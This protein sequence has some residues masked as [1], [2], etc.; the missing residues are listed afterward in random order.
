M[1]WTNPAT[2]EGRE[3]FTET[4]PAEIERALV[5]AERAF[6]GWRRRDF[7]E[8]ARLMRGAARLLRERKT[9]YGR[10][11]ALEMGKPLAQGEAEAEK[12]AWACE[13]YADR[14]PDFLA[15]HPHTS[16]AT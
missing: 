7:A 5:E 9:A 3:T 13:Y 6:A 2:G 16:A 15:H 10:T 11:M 14:P 8:R 12:C 1:E 4:W